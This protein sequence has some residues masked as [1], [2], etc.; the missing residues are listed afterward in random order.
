M[1]DLL[2]TPC[3]AVLIEWR[4]LYVRTMWFFTSGMFFSS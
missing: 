2:E 1:G 3:Y 4:T